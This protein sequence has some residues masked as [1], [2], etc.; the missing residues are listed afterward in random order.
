MPAPLAPELWVHGALRSTQLHGRLAR[1]ILL[2]PPDAEE[3]AAGEQRQHGGAAAVG[4]D[5]LT[6]P[7]VATFEL[8]GCNGLQLE[9]ELGQSAFDHRVDQG[10]LELHALDAAR[11][12]V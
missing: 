12:R 8:T 6:E 4:V 11:E 7:D 3:D 9:A 5:S 1:A 2:V 10:D